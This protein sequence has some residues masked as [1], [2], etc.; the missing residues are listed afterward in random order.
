MFV[1]VLAI[2]V[3]AGALVAAQTDRRET[4][5]VTRVFPT[6]GQLGLFVA[7]ADGTGERRLLTDSELA[8]N[9]TWSPDGTWLVFASEREGSADLY[10]MHADGSARGNVRALR[11]RRVPQLR[12]RVQ[13]WVLRRVAGVRTQL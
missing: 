11:T 4:I 12:V 5:L 13:C 8:Y 2:A 1:R 3:L 7:N 10:R 6:A 9:P